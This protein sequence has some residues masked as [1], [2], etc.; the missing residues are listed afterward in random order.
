M[1]SFLSQRAVALST[2][3]DGWQGPQQLVMYWQ[4]NGGTR[5]PSPQPAGQSGAGA[6]ST[7]SLI[8]PTRASR[9]PPSPAHHH[10]SFSTNFPNPTTRT[11]LIIADHWQGCRDITTDIAVNRS[12]SNWELIKV[13]PGLVQLHV[14]STSLSI[15]HHWWTW[16]PEDKGTC[17][18]EITLLRSNCGKPFFGMQVSLLDSVP[19]ALTI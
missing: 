4:T 16:L 6:I 14:I 10:V 11:R 5:A 9:P 2:L 15:N 1:S 8:R 13:Y 12:V 17:I 18:G 7:L 3:L 19:L